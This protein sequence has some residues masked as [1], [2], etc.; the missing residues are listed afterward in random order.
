MPEI[1]PVIAVNNPSAASDNSREIELAIEQ[2]RS[3][4][5]GTRIVFPP[6]T[7]WLARAMYLFE[8]EASIILEGQGWKTVFV[9][10]FKDYGGDGGILN[11]YCTRVGYADEVSKTNQGSNTAEVGTGVNPANYQVGDCVFLFTGPLGGETRNPCQTL[12]ITGVQGTDLTF[13]RNLDSSDYNAA[14]YMKQSRLVG[15]ANLVPGTT[16]VTLAGNNKADATLFHVG[17]YVFLSDGVGA[18][19]IYGE[20]VK[21]ASVTVNLDDSVTIGF[22]TGIELAYQDGQTV[23]IP[24]P[25]PQNITLR[26]LSL[27][28]IQSTLEG[29][30]LV[31]FAVD[32]VGENVRVWKGLDD[33]SVNPPFR[34]KRTDISATANAR[35]TGCVWEADV[36]INACHDILFLDCTMNG[37]A[38]DEFSRNVHHINGTISTFCTAKYGATR[39]N[40]LGCR[41]RNMKQVF[42]ASDGFVLSGAGEHTILNCVFDS[43]TVNTVYVSGVRNTVAHV[44]G[45]ARRHFTNPSG[46][47]PPDPT[48]ALNNFVQDVRLKAV[49]LNGDTG[50]TVVPPIETTEPF[51]PPPSWVVVP[52]VGPNGMAVN[53]VIQAN[54][55]APITSPP[56][57]L[58]PIPGA[59]PC[60]DPSPSDPP[61]ATSSLGWKVV[62]YDTAY[63][64]GISNFTLAVM[65]G[66]WLS[67]FDDATPP[68][69]NATYLYPDTMAKVSFGTDG[70]GVF[71][72]PV[73]LKGNVGFFGHDP[74]TKPIVSGSKGG[75]EALASLIAGLVSLGEVE[76]RTTE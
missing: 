1:I 48:A 62:L 74:A 5:Q 17:D 76:D 49:F 60:A 45:D 57:R 28:G 34:A 55:Y 53:G 70:S 72:G 24:G 75:N 31:K 29:E 9:C 2:W 33:P 30:W 66:Q 47:V 68:A 41:L 56:P 67:L 7:I 36:G 11:I 65:T 54:G 10:T 43:S 35:F 26:N 46:S 58:V 21:V 23:L 4:P 14:K 38:H 52:E 50:G 73:S 69:N 3:A 44:R 32:F 16:A 22:L 51:Q 42:Q 20:F 64:L 40:L 63:A 8:T 6:G 59:P 18:L 61:R 71:T 37:A 27:G 12:R 25:W 19:E 15:T 39:V 13:D